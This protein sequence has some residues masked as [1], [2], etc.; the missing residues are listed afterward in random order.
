MA[1]HKGLSSERAAFLLWLNDWFYKNLSGQ[2]HMSGMGFMV[3]ANFFLNRSRP[4][5][6]LF[7]EKHRSDGLFISV[8]MVL[9][10]ASELI[11]ELRLPYGEKSKYLWTFIGA[12][13]GLTK[14][15][16]EQRYAKLL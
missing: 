9:A 3:Q 13:W 1:K 12:H 5:I 11:I 14:E 15:V 6:E 2:S 16:Y 8:T 10:L 4:D 7:M